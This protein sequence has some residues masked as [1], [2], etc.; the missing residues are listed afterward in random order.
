MDSDFFA[1]GALPDFVE[2]R[3]T[4]RRMSRL[5][6]LRDELARLD[7][8]L[9]ELVA[10]RQELA[11]AIGGE[12]RRAGLATRDYRQEKDVIERARAAA[13]ELGL[14]PDVAEQL[15]LLLIRSSLT[16][17]EQALVAAAGSGGGKSALVIGG[18]GK[19]GGWFARFLASQGYRVEVADPAGPLAGFP[20]VADWRAADLAHDVIVVAVPLGAAN[21]ILHALAER[22]PSGLV[23]DVGSLKSPL[24]SGL[25][26]LASAGVRVTSIHPMFGPGTELLSGRHVVFVDV[27][28]AEATRAAQELFAS[29]MAARVTMDLE[30]HDR[31]IAYVLGLSHALNIAFFTALAESGEAAP[32]LAELSSTTFEAQLAVAN[33]VAGESPHL[34]YEIQRLNDYGTESLAALALAVDRVRTVVRAGDEAGFVRLMEQGRR[35]LEARRA[36]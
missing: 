7:R 5:D 22:R 3:S 1:R 35:Y 21:E 32:R 13:A 25:R 23:F 9:L 15:A 12:K 8:R 36:P 29:T 33:A 20:H 4:M 14:P 34:Y 24:R 31:V 17:Q 30:E 2:R 6:D 28:S 18:R 11:H 10:R 16:V 19:M 26:A 27:G